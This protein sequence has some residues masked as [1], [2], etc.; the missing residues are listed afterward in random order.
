M[1]RTVLLLALLAR[2]AHA[3][4]EGHPA[5]KGTI[6]LGI[7]LGEPTG[8]CGKIYLSDDQAIQAALGAAFYGGGLQAHADYVFHPWILQDRETFVLPVYIG[9][10]MRFIQ[11]NQGRTEPSHF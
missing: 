3:D 2:I 6:G 11:Y 4:E 8:I 1:R 7:I 10:G 5:E 9:P